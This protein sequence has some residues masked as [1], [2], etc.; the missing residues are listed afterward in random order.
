[1]HSRH[2]FFRMGLINLAIVAL[3]GVA[4]RYKILFELPFIDYRNLLSAHSHFAFV[5]WVSLMVLTLLV[6]HLL[7][8]EHAV[9]K[10]FRILLFAVNLCGYGM[11]A[12]FPFQGY[13]AISI[14]FSSAFIVVT[15]VFA[16]AYL[17]A[18]KVLHRNV[19]LL[20]TCALVSLLLSA[21]GP[22]LLGYIK[23][24]GSTNSV[25]YRDAI[26]SFLHLQYNGFFSLAL[27]AHF[28]HRMGGHRAPRF[29]RIFSISLCASVVPTLFL[30]LFWHNQVLL[31]YIAAL[32][33][34]FLVIALFSFLRIWR[35]PGS[36][37]GFRQ[38]LARRLIRLSFLC[39]CLKLLLQSCTLVPRLANA[40]YGDRPVIIG[41]LH[42]VFL[43]FVSLYLLAVLVEEGYFTRAHGMPAYPVYIFVSAVFTNEALLMLQGLGILLGTYSRIFNWGLLVAA[44][45]LF[46]GAGTMAAFALRRKLR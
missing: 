15:Y 13:G 18:I 7:P 10:K 26:Y 33:V 36:L 19:R 1:M 44:I 25:L 32:G 42:L 21:A 35:Q 9:R 28:L 37:L 29:A 6:H 24:T 30:S 23:A 3:L 22:I 45:L 5:G 12:S 41:F 43:G 8:S 17:P 16:F 14:F 31:Y 2:L 11:L 39:F 20:A 27:C 34:L 4:L 38:P 40:V 46:T